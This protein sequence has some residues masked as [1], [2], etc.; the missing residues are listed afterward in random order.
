MSEKIKPDLI[1]NMKREWFAKIWNGEKTIEYRERKPYW[2]KRIGNWVGQRGK[3]VL[4]VLGYQRRTPAMLL[5]VDRVS[6]GEC[7]YEGWGGEYYQ[8]HFAVVG[9]YFKDGD[10]YTPVMGFIPMKEK[11]G[12]VK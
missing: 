3:F 9:Y 4:M 11:K 6:I 1:L 10:A 2:D 5:Q 12:E 7:P 8:L